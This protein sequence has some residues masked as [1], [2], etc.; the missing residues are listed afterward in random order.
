MVLRFIRLLRGY[1]EFVLFGRFPERFIN[2]LT[3]EGIRSWDIMPEK[4]MYNGKMLLTDYRR[5]RPLARRAGVRLK[6]RKR[7]G[8]PFFLKKYRR[9]RGLL[10]GAAAGL[11]LLTVLSQFVWDI[12]ISGVNTLSYSKVMAALSDNGLYPGCFKPSL[13]VSEIERETELYVPDISWISINILNNIA[14]VEI[15][16]KV[17][18][19]GISDT[20]TP[21]NIKASDDGVIT[22]IIVHSGSC[23]LKRGTAVTKNSLLVSSVIED[24]EQNIRYVHSDAEIFADVKADK[25]FKIPITNNKIVFKSET[26]ERSRLRFLWAELPLSLAPRRSDNFVSV[27]SQRRVIFNS[28][29]LPIGDSLERLYYYSN[30]EIKHTPDEA[31]SILKKKAALYECFCEGKGRVKTRSFNFKRID[32]FDVLSASYVFNKNIAVKQRLKVN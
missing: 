19:P 8:L 13:T 20:K 31:K 2:L 1:V 18:K 27:F 23:T 26:D 24:N 3:R 21:C 7:S 9:R 17:R 12:R 5:I 25:V 29:T 4:G 11:V 10:I 32:G 15:K 22:D 16:E 30:S 6:V 28:V 14:E